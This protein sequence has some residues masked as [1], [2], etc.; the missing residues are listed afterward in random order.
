MIK[1]KECVPLAT[2]W[3]ELRQSAG[4]K[5]YDLLSSENALKTTLYGVSVYDN[6]SIIGMARVIGDGF[7]CFYIQDVIVRS[8]YQGQGIGK[9]MMTLIMNYIEKYAAKNAV[10][11]LMSAKGREGFYEKFGFIRR[12]NDN[13]GCGMIKFNF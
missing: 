9:Q 2:E 6:D 5:L 12:P 13:L 7:T 4:W 8:V 1:I 11:G 3:I 10:I